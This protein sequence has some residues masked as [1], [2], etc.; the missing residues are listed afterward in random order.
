[1][2]GRSGGMNGD[3][4][5]VEVA[6]ERNGT[7]WLVDPIPALKEAMGG[8]SVPT[9]LDTVPYQWDHPQRNLFV[10]TNSG[11]SHA[12]QRADPQATKLYDIEH[13]ETFEAVAIVPGN[14]G[15][16]WWLLTDGTRVPA[17]NTE[18]KVK[19]G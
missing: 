5:H 14:D 7:Y 8:T 17:K 18:A 1:M 4:V 10:V 15:E 11:I 19:V 6:V 12:Y 16:H 3:H 2:V 9:P 13:D